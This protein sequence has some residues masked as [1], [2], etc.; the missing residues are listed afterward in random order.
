MRKQMLI[1]IV[2][3]IVSIVSSNSEALDLDEPNPRSHITTTVPEQSRFE[4]TQSSIAAKNTFK[5]DKFTGKVYQIV[6]KPDGGISWDEILKIKHSLDI[7]KE[8]Q[9]NYQLYMSGLA[10]RFTFLINVWTGATWQLT[11][12]TKTGMLFWE[13]VI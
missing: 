6:Q 9:V 3:F 12:D 11:Q 1:T 7:T 8:N 5:I 4:F 13:P 2:L 10:V